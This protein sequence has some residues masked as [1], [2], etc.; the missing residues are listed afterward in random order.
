MPEP[1]KTLLRRNLFEVFS[2]RSEETRRHVIAKIWHP[3]GV[4]V[5]PDGRWVGR[6][7]INQT[8]EKL[9][10]KFPGFVFT[11]R[12]VPTA[13]HGVGR[14][15][16]GFGPAGAPPVVTGMDVGEAAFGKLRTLYTF[17]DQGAA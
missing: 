13:F 8:V 7:E 12:S 9:L 10:S 5:N 17:I 14:I 6:V 2:E 1:I 4:I 16:W 3:D 11:E 15:A